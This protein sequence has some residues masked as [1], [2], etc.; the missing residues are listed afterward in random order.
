MYNLFFLGYNVGGLG[1]VIVF[2]MIFLSFVK[3]LFWFK[4]Y[5]CCF[6]DVLRNIKIGV[7]NIGF[8]VV[9]DSFDLF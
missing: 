1:T 9:G 2:L 4:N 6:N 7:R 5:V 3:C 8:F